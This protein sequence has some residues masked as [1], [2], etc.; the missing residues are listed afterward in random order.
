MCKDIEKQRDS[1]PGWKTNS[2][3]NILM[4]SWETWSLGNTNFAGP[5]LTNACDDQL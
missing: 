4:A 5:M 3:R 1:A 2:R